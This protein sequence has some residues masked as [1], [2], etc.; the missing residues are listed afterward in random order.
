[1]QGGIGNGADTVPLTHNGD[2]RTT[3]DGKTSTTDVG[4]ADLYNL[5]VIYKN[6]CGWWNN[7]MCGED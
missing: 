1:V 7:Y 5:F 6:N 2:T 3:A 4:G